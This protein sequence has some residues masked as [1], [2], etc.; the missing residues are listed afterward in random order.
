[1]T[2]Q[3][4]QEKNIPEKNPFAI[5]FYFIRCSYLC[6]KGK[7][8]YLMKMM[9]K[10]RA[11]KNHDAK[12]IYE[13]L[14]AKEEFLFDFSVFEINY[15]ICIGDVR[16]IYLVAVDENNVATGFISCHGQT[17]LHSGGVVF[18]IRELYVNKKWRK[19]GTG[20]LLM[21]KLQE[22]LAG[23]DHQLLEVTVI[24]KRSD[25]IQFYKNFGFEMTHVKMIKNKK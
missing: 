25:L 16:N 7:F 24:S 20:R 22:L 4:Y 11:A 18:E 8:V 17:V 12:K 19:S 14:C 1:L 23:I 10:I 2:I 3:K 6:S 5:G 15:R 13:F 21:S 9:M